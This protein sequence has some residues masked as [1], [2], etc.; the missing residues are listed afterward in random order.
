MSA[1]R[2]AQASPVSSPP[3]GHTLVTHAHAPHTLLRAGAWQCV[4]ACVS[5]NRHVR[6]S[7]S[8]LLRPWRP[9]RAARRFHRSGASGSSVGPKALR[10]SFARPSG[11]SPAQPSRDHP[12][13]TCRVHHA[14]RSM[15]QSLV[16][17]SRAE[18]IDL[19]RCA[20]P[21]CARSTAM[22]PTGHHPTGATSSSSGNTAN[23]RPQ[24]Q[25]GNR[26]VQQRQCS[27]HALA[28]ASRPAHL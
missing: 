12:R 27:A 25:S 15:L 11:P 24:R 18:R 7:R 16:E 4:R 17:P 10:R 9:R 13:T 2:H 3:H 26:R 21:C 22:H 28:Q 20:C 8:A 19:G 6:A 14:S 1:V 23:T 5:I